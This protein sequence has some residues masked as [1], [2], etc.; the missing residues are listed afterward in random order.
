MNEAEEVAGDQGLSEGGSLSS[1]GK[2]ATVQ[3]HAMVVLSCN[4][5]SGQESVAAP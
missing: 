2:S 1:I 3:V 4:L 5:L